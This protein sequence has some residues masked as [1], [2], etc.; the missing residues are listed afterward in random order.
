V[1]I[2]LGGRINCKSRGEFLGKKSGDK[3]EIVEA[4][5]GLPGRNVRWDQTGKEATKVGLITKGKDQVDDQN[6]L[7]ENGSHEANRAQESRRGK[8]RD[9]M[10]NGLRRGGAPI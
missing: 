5:R 2:D 1:G 6:Y 7:R 4:N 9:I 8:K 3:K 10:E